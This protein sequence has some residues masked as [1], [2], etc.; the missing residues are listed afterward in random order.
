MNP[1]EEKIQA[2]IIQSL[3]GSLA[4]QLSMETFRVRLAAY[5]NDLINRDFEK[6]VQLLYRLDVSEKKLKAMLSQPSQA[7]AGQV[8]ADLILERQLQKVELRKKFRKQ[9]DISEE[10]KW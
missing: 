5:L 6:L 10:E 1:V 4:P 3:G 9:D 2:E 7:D 8:I